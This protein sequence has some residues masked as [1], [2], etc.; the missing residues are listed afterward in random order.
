MITISTSYT[1]S[2][3]EELRR[4][5]GQKWCSR[6]TESPSCYTG[7]LCRRAISL[8]V[9]VDAFSEREAWDASLRRRIRLTVSQPRQVP[10]M[11][12]A[13]PAIT[14]PAFLPVESWS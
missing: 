3:F 7:Q 5:K 1:S 9:P 11:P 2:Y 10:M 12:V 6:S 4:A 14:R 8:R 13:K